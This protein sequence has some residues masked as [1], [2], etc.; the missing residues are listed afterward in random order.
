M[1][2]KREKEA[3]IDQLNQELDEI[4]DIVQKEKLEMSFQEQSLNDLKEKANNIKSFIKSNPL[5]SSEVDKLAKREKL[6]ESQ[7]L[8]TLEFLNSKIDTEILQTNNT[9][10]NEDDDQIVSIK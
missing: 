2:F 6:R 5:Y 10:D 1:A 4:D 7:D 8:K 9:K 3:E